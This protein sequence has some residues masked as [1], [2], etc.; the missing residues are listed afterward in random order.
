MK[1]IITY[2]SKVVL[3]LYVEET[4]QS[5]KIGMK[6]VGGKNENKNDYYT[7]VG[8]FQTFYLLIIVTNQENRK[9]LS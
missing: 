6:F 7:V 5:A 4:V 1:Y 8:R 3:S 2:K 9:W